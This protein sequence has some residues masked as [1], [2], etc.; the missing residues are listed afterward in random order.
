VSSADRWVFVLLPRV[1]RKWLLALKFL[2]RTA[3][4]L[5]ASSDV[6][7]RFIRGPTLLS[8]FN[9]LNLFTELSH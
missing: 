1:V 8:Q 5:N 3:G 2:D 4:L 6:K 9:T 7:F